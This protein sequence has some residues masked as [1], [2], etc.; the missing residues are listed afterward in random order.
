MKKI[1]LFVC[2]LGFLKSNAQLLNGKTLVVPEF[3]NGLIK[4]YFATSTTT[5]APNAAYTINLSTLPNGLATGG[6]PN[7]VAMYGTDL[8]V[9]I[10]GA[11][12]R[13]YRFPGYGTNPTNAIA[14][15]SQVTN[16]GNDYVGLAFDSS[17]N[18][19]VSEGS[20][21][22]TNL[23]KY[24]AASG[25]ATRVDLGNG[26]LTSYF[27]NITF[28][29][30]GNLWAT[31]YLNNRVVGI[32]NADRHVAS[33]IFHSL[34]TNSASWNAGSHW[35]ENT[36]PVLKAKNHTTVF[37][38]P[39]GVFASGTNLWVANNNDSG[40]NEA[41][42]IVRISGTILSQVLATANTTLLP[43]DSGNQ[44]T[45]YTVW[46]LPS[47][48]SGRSQLGGLQ[49][50]E[51]VSRLYVNEEV[52]QKGLWFDIGS[53]TTITDNFATYQMGIVS[54]NPGNGGLYL[55]N[56]SQVLDTDDFESTSGFVAVYPNP[57]TDY[58][59][60]PATTSLL[61]ITAYDLLGRSVAVQ[62]TGD[63]Q[64]TI[65]EKGVY[66]L[67]LQFENGKRSLSKIVIA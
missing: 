36:D 51:A 27:A 44:V 55:A 53:L 66:F 48:A 28:D 60:V 13:I 46:N 63:N 24:A 25:Y 41:A 49:I 1:L 43:A 16:V 20:S 38:Q 8:F 23:V 10:T 22:D 34:F 9:T 12:Q 67:V 65:A 57:T 56:T 11:N 2:F 50:D 31:D 15:V 26:G 32:K 6:S 64:Y 33:T 18:M 4:T 54:T 3:S 7:C 42:T 52:S 29:A 17:G 30:N 19:Y 58:F 21:L 37:S 62:K 40:A 5:I 39:E 14:N 35:I 45:G 47:S 59:T 61:A